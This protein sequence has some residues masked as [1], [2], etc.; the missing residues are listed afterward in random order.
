MRQDEHV[1]RE[2]VTSDVGDLPGLLRSALV[3]R[4]PH[5]PAPLG[6]AGVVLAV[7]A[8]E[9]ELVVV[10][11]EVAVQVEVEELLRVA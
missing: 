2:A 3:Q 7:G 8:D 5:R 6:T 1:G 9:V 10:R 11:R 4:L